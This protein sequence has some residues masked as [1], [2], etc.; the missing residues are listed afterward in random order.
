MQYYLLAAAMYL[1]MAW[2][3]MQAARWM[4][5]RFARG[6]LQGGRA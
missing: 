5:R 3:M 1:V 6:R 4:E 2:P